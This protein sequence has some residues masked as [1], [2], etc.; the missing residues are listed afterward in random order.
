MGF[1]Q[2]YNRKR[3]IITLPD[4]MSLML[5]YTIGF[6]ILWLLIVLAFYIIGIPLGIHTGVML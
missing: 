2:I 5:P 6:T 3:K 1:I 4:A